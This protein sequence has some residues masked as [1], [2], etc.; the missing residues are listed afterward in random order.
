MKHVL[1]ID[2]GYGNTKFVYGCQDAN[3]GQW[4]EM[5]FRSVTPR[6]SIED[7]SSL[8]SND[9][10][11][12]TVGGSD[13]YVGPKAS[14]T[15]GSSTL[16]SDYIVTDEYEALIQGAWHYS[17]K[18][19][20][21]THQAIDVLVLGLPV[22]GFQANKAILQ[23]IGRKVRTIPVPKELRARVGAET[24]EVFAKRVVVVPQPYGALRLA[25]EFDKNSDIFE[26]DGRSLVIDPGYGT[27]DWYVS[28]SMAARLDLCGSFQGGVSKIIRAVSSKMGFDEGIGSQDYGLV[29]KAL[30]SGVFRTNTKNIDMTK[31]RDFAKQVADAS[32]VEFL[33]RFNPSDAGVSR[34]FLCGGGSAHFY[35][36]LQKRL[37]NFTIGLMEDSM[38]ANARGFY[39]AG[40]E[41]ADSGN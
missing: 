41:I 32:V 37:P 2:V 29:E 31:Y 23:Q 14:Y 15:G 13:F 9:R 11:K 19:Q 3:R 24:M 5:S 16:S 4:S 26:D 22:S 8:G 12:V 34:I 21:A 40:R 28:E 17:L 36:A 20:Q 30:D 39:L 35:E 27:F 33:K 25:A 7:D 1:A 18:M 38:M 6:V 10:V